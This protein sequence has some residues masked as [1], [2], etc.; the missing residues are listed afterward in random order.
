MATLSAH[1]TPAPSR[2]L[3]G[4]LCVEIAML[5]FVGQDAMMKTLLT[6]YPVWLLIFVRSI[7]TLLV[8]TPLILILGAPHRLLTPLWP[9]HLLRAFL[10]ATGFSMF[11][12]AF[13]FMGLAEVSTIF[14]S[15]P[16]ITA[17]FASVFLRE[18]IGPHRCA[19]LVVGFIGVLIAMNP[20]GE[21]FSWVAILPLLCA[22]T[23]AISQII[24][25][26]IGDR[27]S[28][29]TVGLY[30]LT[31]AGLLILPMGWLVNQVIEITP[32]THHLRWEL[33]PEAFGDLPRLALLGVIGMAAYSLVSRAYQIANASLVA[34]F[35]Y[36]YLPFAA[37]LAYVLWDEVPALNVLAGMMLI[38]ASGLY[39]GWRE[40]RAARHSDE[41]PVTAEAI[42]APGSP[43]PPQIPEEESAK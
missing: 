14:F 15:A 17:L 22:V 19:A 38:I 37:I 35:D 33:P 36:T 2:A 3:Q 11:Y 12:A 31:F 30:T 26:Q 23:Y 6:L 16:L 32:A 34:P 10:F 9:L 42:F 20:A 43:L 21:N 29:L 18:T 5:L 13:P 27:E 39:L 41:V 1:P 8:M 4:I 24:A 7:V 40:L 28:T 25:R